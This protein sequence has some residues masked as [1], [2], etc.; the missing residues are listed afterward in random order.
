MNEKLYLHYKGFVGIECMHLF[1]L[2][3]T[4]YFEG[5]LATEIKGL[6]SSS[7]LVTLFLQ[8]NMIRKIEGLN[9]LVNL[10]TLNLADNLIEVVEGLSSCTKL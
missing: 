7:K 1:P 3:T 4:L 8:E 5:N 10:K 2:A 9:A 6:D